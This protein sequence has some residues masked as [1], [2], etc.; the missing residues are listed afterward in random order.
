MKRQSAS[1]ATAIGTG[2]RA[3]RSA[4]A[5]SRARSSSEVASVGGSNSVASVDI[6]AYGLWL[7]A[8]ADMNERVFAAE[9]LE[10]R[11]VVAGKTRHVHRIAA[12]DIDFVLADD[13]VP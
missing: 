13:A 8:S 5:R 2:A 12:E 11:V 10:L 4:R 9:R 1:W 7:I 6:R 3:T